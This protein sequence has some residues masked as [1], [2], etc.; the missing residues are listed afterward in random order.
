MPV[1]SIWQRT[2]LKARLLSAMLA[3][4]GVL[5]AVNSALHL[6][7]RVQEFLRDATE[8]SI[9]NAR[10][11]QSFVL[12]R[13]A[14]RTAKIVPPPQDIDE[15]AL[16]WADILK[17]D[18]TI[19]HLIRNIV[20]NSKL[21]T[22]VYITDA[23]GKILNAV[24]EDQI[25]QIYRPHPNLAQWQAGNVFEKLQQILYNG[26]DYEIVI[27]LG[28]AEQSTPLFM[29]RAVVSSAML[30][31]SLRPELLTIGISSAVVLIASIL[32]GGFLA[33]RI[34]QPLKRLTQA[35][36]QVSLGGNMEIEPK[37]TREFATV[38]SKLY[39]LAQRFRGAREDVVQLR[40][41]IER[42][43]QRLEEAVLL[44]DG[45]DTLIVA[46]SPAERLLGRERRKL[47]GARLEELFPASTSIG[48]AIQTARQFRQHL[49]DYPVE[50]PREGGPPQH[51]LLNVDPFHEEDGSKGTL[52]TLRDAETRTQLEAQLDVSTRLA[53]IS[54][55]TGGVAHE[56]KNPLNAITLHLEVLRA[57]IEKEIPA[58]IPEV[59]IIAMEVE[60]LNRVVKAFV[61][62]TRPMPLDLRPVDLL[63]ITTECVNRLRSEAA[64]RGIEMDLKSGPEQAMILG[65]ATMLKQAVL[66]VLV[67]AIEAM[68]DGGRIEIDVSQSLGDLVLTISD[69]GNGIPAE[70]RDK[71]FNL[72]Y[73]TKKAGAGVGLAI[74][75]QVVQLHNG[76]IDCAD[77]PTQGTTFR[78]RF[79]SMREPA[80]RALG[81]EGGG[82]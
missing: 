81:A 63:E 80:R 7:W 28:V 66:N 53:A 8:R 13:V 71:I 3:L 57:Q 34:L 70:I 15:S 74:A 69:E 60:R 31:A 68:K 45:R 42:M 55:L 50:I 38:Q 32:L 25:G 17:S 73:T 5:V 78:L 33:N 30:W 62:F 14:E 24:S 65:D 61:E 39:L 18:P 6:Y 10:D 64:R 9:N 76:S 36:D 49:R 20:V 46:G 43:L 4:V 19:R 56:I 35:I 47:V 16:L 44:F 21:V 77:R 82:R 23:S 79:P 41:N 58:A 40:A 2:S 27:P 26:R 11:V 75:F 1:G 72:F 48:A 67:N 22:D 51:L 54:R 37:E 29:I 52:I 12:E 59:D